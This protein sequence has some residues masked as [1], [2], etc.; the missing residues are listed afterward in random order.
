MILTSQCQLTML[1]IFLYHFRYFKLKRI[2]FPPR[3]LNASKLLEVLVGKDSRACLCIIGLKVI[4]LLLWRGCWETAAAPDAPT[5]ATAAKTSHPHG[6]Q[7]DT[8]TLCLPTVYQPLVTGRWPLAS[9]PPFKYCLRAS[10][11]IQITS[12]GLIA[13]EFRKCR[14]WTSS[15]SK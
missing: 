11:R 12:R 2:F 3:E 10:E 7:L 1:P 5:T 4:L 9:F 6:W 15:L 13:R 8:G 14:F